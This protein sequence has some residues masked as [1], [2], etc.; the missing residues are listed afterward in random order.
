V[1]AGSS[2]FFRALSCWMMSHI[3]FIS[4]M[5]VCNV[6]NKYYISIHQIVVL[7]SR[8]TPILVYKDITVMTN[9]IYFYI[10]FELQGKIAFVQ[11]CSS[12]FT[13]GHFVSSV[14]STV[15]S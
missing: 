2:G 7:D 15:E 4:A 12:D 3:H 8:Y 6:C 5:Y 11:K 13:V 14:H 9:H 10:L 1:D